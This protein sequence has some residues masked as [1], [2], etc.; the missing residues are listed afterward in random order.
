MLTRLMQVNTEQE[1]IIQ[2]QAALI[3]ELFALVCQYTNLEI[4]E[5]LT[6]LLS[7]IGDVAERSNRL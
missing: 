2:M 7:S 3:D 4:E 5:G 6:P 1:K